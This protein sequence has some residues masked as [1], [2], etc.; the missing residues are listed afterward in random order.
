MPGSGKT[1]IG[2]LLSDAL[3]KELVD[4]DVLIEEYSGLHHKNIL[5]TKGYEELL[6]IEEELVLNLSLTNKIFAPSGSII[7]SKKAMEKIKKET[8]VIYLNLDKE[9]LRKRLDDP[10]HRK[11]IVG[12]KEHGFDRLF[13][14]RSALYSKYS[15]RTIDI[16]KESKEE[17]EQIILNSLL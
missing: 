12:L 3:N 16:K 10:S 7:Y 5:E 2:E 15:D 8:F 9:I 17:L 4:L 6:Q 13:E 1:T 11:G 14:I